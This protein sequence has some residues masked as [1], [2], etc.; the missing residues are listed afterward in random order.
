[1]KR[2]CELMVK[3]M[4]VMVTVSADCTSVPTTGSRQG[5]AKIWKLPVAVG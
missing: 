2:F 4:S 1:M 3:V 5:Q